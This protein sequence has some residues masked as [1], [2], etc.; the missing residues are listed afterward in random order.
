MQ[1]LVVV[2]AATLCIVPLGARAVAAPMQSMPDSQEATRNE[3]SRGLPPG[4]VK[5][6]D[7]IGKMVLSSQT[8]KLGRVRDVVID[9]R[10]SRAPLVIAQPTD[11]LAI[12]LAAP[13]QYAAVPSTLLFTADGKVILDTDRT[14]LAPRFASDRWPDLERAW[15]ES[16]YRDFGQNYTVEPDTGR[17][18]QER[19]ARA[20]EF[21]GSTVLDHRGETLGKAE[22]LVLDLRSGEVRYVVFSTGGV[23]G[24]MDKLFAVPLDQFEVAATRRELILSVEKDRLE[25]ADGFRKDS[26]PATASPSWIDQVEQLPLERRPPS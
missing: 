21:L 17:T 23:M 20:T 5:A 1:T 3:F 11:Q 8:R 15:V 7:L 26:W 6:G 19:F 25:K 12:G 13:P 24:I 2:V 18:R 9:R 4:C 10:T 22:D 14:Q 16:V